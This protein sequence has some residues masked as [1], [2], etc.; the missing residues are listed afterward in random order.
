MNI[1]VITPPGKGY[2]LVNTVL[3]GLIELK[4]EGMDLNLAFPDYS[5]LAPFDI[6]DFTMSEDKFISFAQKADLIILTWGKNVTNY[7]LAEKINCWPKTIFVEESEL[8]KNNRYDFD[9]QKSVLDLT[10]KSYGRID[11]E[12]LNKCRLYFRREKPYIKGIIPLPFGIESRYLEKFSEKKEKDIDFACMFGQDQYPIMRRHVSKILSDF[13]QE[14]NFK[15][16]VGKTP[17][18]SFDDE[19]KKAGRSDFYEILARSKVGISVGGGGFDT[20]RF[21]EILANNCLLLTEKIDIYEPDS[22]RLKYDRIWQFSNLFDFEYELNKA[23][24]FLRKE[25]R[26]EDLV[27]EYQKIISEHSSKTRVLEIINVFNSLNNSS[28]H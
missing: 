25:Y 21:W 28:S 14:N 2:Y 13:C 22:S 4:K 18:F 11:E 15:C 6:K 7:A 1:A 10:Y 24:Q 26:S 20:A 9:I 8:G 5:Y 3:D 23:G 19:T 12:M 17:S 16:F 27:K